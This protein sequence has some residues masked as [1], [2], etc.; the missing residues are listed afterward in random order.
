M[1]DLHD[2]RNGIHPAAALDREKDL[3][4]ELM[5][6]HIVDD[7]LVVGRTEECG[8]LLIEAA[9]QIT[10]FEVVK[11][12]KLNIVLRRQILLTQREGMHRGTCDVTDEEDIVGRERENAC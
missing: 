1:V 2:R 9:D 7:D 12:A 11:I 6:H 8:K 3:L 4:S 10:T 5:D